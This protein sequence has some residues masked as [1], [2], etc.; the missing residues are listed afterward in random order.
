MTVSRYAV[1]FAPAVDHPLWHA[2]S[3][4]LGRD[5]RAGQAATLPAATELQL[6]WRYGFHATLK[7]PM[8]LA[9]GE[10]EADW[11]HDVQMLAGQQRRFA[12]PAL[13]VAWLAD[14]LALRPVE[15]VHAADP[16]RQ[17]ADACVMQLDARRVELSDI[18]HA[19]QLRP[20]FSE[21]QRLNVQRHGYA[22]VLD[23]WR[24]HF[25]LSGPLPD[26]GSDH[27]DALMNAA[28]RHFAT[29]LQAPLVCDALCVYQEPAPGAPFVLTHRF[30]FS[31]E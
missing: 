3:T 29:A 18:E 11:L 4:W 10:C 15:S 8:A 31:N 2:G 17:L 28:Q 20:A 9:A 12:M 14:F 13:S 25:T 26:A 24:F 6:P 5:A 23:D 27:Y 16:L 30:G 7:A 1:Y 22:H 19:R 21:R